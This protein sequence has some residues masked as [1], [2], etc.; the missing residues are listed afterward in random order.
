MIS[1]E[2]KDKDFEVVLSSP[3]ILP[4]KKLITT[5]EELRKEDSQ[6]RKII[7]MT[8]GCFD[9][10]HLGHLYALKK[11]KSFCDVLIVGV[12]SDQSVHHL[13]GNNRPV[14]DEKTRSLLIAAL[15]YVDYVMLFDEASAAYFVDIVQPNLI[16]KDK[17]KLCDWPN[18]E[19]ISSFGGKMIKLDKIDGYST[20]DIIKKINDGNVK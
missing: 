10:L 8:S 16:I 6:D 3:K 15:I 9:L 7:G 14:Q 11:A 18:A 2:H 20:T 4:W 17:Y 13:K 19:K 12:N 5:M 1:D